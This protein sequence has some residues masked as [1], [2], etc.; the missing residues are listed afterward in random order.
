MNT[1]VL[2]STET[3]AARLDEMATEI[4]AFYTGKPL[5]VLAILNGSLVFAADLLRRIHLPL[6]FECLQVAS[7]H[8]GLESSGVVTFLQNTLPDL[9]KRHVLVLD[10]ILDTGRTL[11]AV[12]LKLLQEAKPADV[13]VAVLL[14][15]RK[16][17]AEPM[18]ADYVGFQI[19]DEFA[20]GYGLDYEGR[21]RNLPEVRV[22]E[23][24]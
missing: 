6:H 1:R 20:I 7:Y 15:K 13:R 5:T 12:K 19:E 16:E 23:P 2:F 24:K 11:H 17:R 9:K 14:S 8:G 4:T 21:Y 3:I 18:E 22:L 10:D